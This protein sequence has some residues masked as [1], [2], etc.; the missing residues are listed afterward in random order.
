MDESVEER[1]A[2]EIARMEERVIEAFLVWQHNHSAVDHMAKTPDEVQAAWD[3]AIVMQEQM[4]SN[5]G[6]L[7]LLVDEFFGE[8]V[9]DID[10]EIHRSGGTRAEVTRTREAVE[11]MSADVAMFRIKSENGGIPAR[12]TLSAN[13]KVALWT[14]AITAAA[15]IGVA[16]IALLQAILEGT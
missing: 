3:N 9:V 15:S 7:D 10:G 14:V 5:S 4:A 16:S 1:L 8:A 11:S 12:L 13:Q 6:K 2:R